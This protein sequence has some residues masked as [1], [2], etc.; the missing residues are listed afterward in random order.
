MIRFFRQTILLSVC[1]LALGTAVVRAESIPA[2][3]GPKAT[4]YATSYRM[5]EGG[6]WKTGFPGL[7][8]FEVLAPPTAADKKTGYNCIAHTIRVYNKWVWPGTKVADFDRLYGSHGYKRMRKLDY[9]F[10]AEL[11]KIV[12]YAKVHKN[13]VIECTHGARQLADG[14]WTSKLGSGP[15]IRHATPSA[16][17]GPSYGR[18]IAVY[19]KVRRT[20]PIVPLPSTTPS[21][22]PTTIA[23]ADKTKSPDR[24]D[25]TRDDNVRRVKA[26]IPGRSPQPE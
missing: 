5:M 13:G 6:S 19:V 23:G 9:R 10:N 22:P 8:R 14:T 21:R 20:P 24:T 18:P 4:V 16:V 17:G 11:D 12:L 15:L 3:P 26:N 7:G 1:V 2:K 25:R